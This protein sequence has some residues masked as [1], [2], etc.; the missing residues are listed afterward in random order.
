MTQQTLADPSA[1]YTL[2]YTLDG[3]GN[4]TQTDITN[5]RGYIERLTFNGNHYIVSDVEA[6]N[7]P[8]QRTRTT[9]RQVGS[10]LVTATVDGLSRRT[11]YTYDG[12]GHVL[13]VTRLA[14]TS[15]AA[16][17]TF[18]YEPLFNQ[19]ATTTDPLGHTWT[20]GYDAQGKLASVS[21]PLTHHTTV[22]MN[23]A[24]QVTRASDA[25]Q[26]TWQWGYGSGDLV[27]TTDPLDAVSRRFLDGAGR[28]LSTTDPL[29]RMTRRV[30]IS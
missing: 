13:T 16:T 10:N 28:V 18:T 6:L 27:S 17:T 26:H 5:P 8:Q 22:V 25:L 4:I 7:T 23:A 9:E 19:M 11:E 29:G 1:V 30:P 3:S 20:V 15:D 14:G 12:A 2:A 24:G 21:D